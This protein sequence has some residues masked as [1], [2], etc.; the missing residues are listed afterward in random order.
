MIPDSFRR[1]D[2]TK[3]KEELDQTEGAALGVKLLIREIASIKVPKVEPHEF[4][5]MYMQ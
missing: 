4:V 2:I 1:I 5:M 3:F